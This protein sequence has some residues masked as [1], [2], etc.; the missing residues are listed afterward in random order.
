[1]EVTSNAIFSRY[2]YANCFYGFVM[3]FMLFMLFMLPKTIVFTS[4]MNVFKL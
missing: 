3:V 1:M 4:S 2:S